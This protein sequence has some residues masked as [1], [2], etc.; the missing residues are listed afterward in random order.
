M[1]SKSRLLDFKS[2]FPLTFCSPEFLALKEFLHKLA[3]KVH[4]FQSFLQRLQVLTKG[5][6]WFDSSD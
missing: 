4:E 6:N 3:K 2:V 1:N 5:E